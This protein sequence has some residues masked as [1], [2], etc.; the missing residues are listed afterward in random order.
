MRSRCIRCC[1]SMKLA[2]PMP[3]WPMPG[4]PPN[5]PRLKG[6][7]A[8]SAGGGTAAPGPAAGVLLGGRVLV[9]SRFDKT[10]WRGLGRARRATPPRPV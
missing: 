4:I 1:I 8:G 3:I 10:W 6:D 2:E 7:W 9:F 5:A